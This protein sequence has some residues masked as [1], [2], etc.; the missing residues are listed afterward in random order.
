M[1]KVVCAQGDAVVR[2]AYIIIGKVGIYETCVEQK[3]G[4]N[5]WY[6]NGRRAEGMEVGRTDTLGRFD[7]R[8]RHTL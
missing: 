4:S 7:V 5:S 3:R 6:S 2:S 8:K 1:S